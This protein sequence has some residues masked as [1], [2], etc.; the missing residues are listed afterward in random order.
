VVEGEPVKGRVD[1][2]TKFEEKGA[3]ARDASSVAL[4]GLHSVLYLRDGVGRE[5]FS[6]AH[7][8]VPAL[9][10]PEP[11]VRR[12]SGD[13]FD[14]VARPL[15]LTIGSDCTELP[16]RTYRDLISLS[17]YPGVV[18]SMAADVDDLGY[19]GVHRLAWEESGAVV[20]V[21]QA[22]RDT[23]AELVAR[24]DGPASTPVRQPN[25]HA[26][27]W[28]DPAI[29]G[30]VARILDAPIDEAAPLVREAIAHRAIG[31]DYIVSPMLVRARRHR[32][33]GWPN[34]LGA[35][36]PD[37]AFLLAGVK[38]RMYRNVPVF[39]EPDGL[40]SESVGRY[41]DMA[42][43]RLNVRLAR[44]I[45]SALGPDADA[46]EAACGERLLAIRR[47]MNELLLARDEILRVARRE[48]LGPRWARPFDQGPVSGASG[49]DVISMLEYHSI[50]ALNTLN[51]VADNLAWVAIRRS[52][53]ALDPADRSVGLRALLAADTRRAWRADVAVRTVAERLA[54]CPIAHT[55]LG[56]LSVRNAFAHR[57]GVAIGRVSLEASLPAEAY[58]V[59]ALW[60][61]RDS[62]NTIRLLPGTD[63]DVMGAIRRQ[64]TFSSGETTVFTFTRFADTILSCATALTHVT[65]GVGPWRSP[66]GWLLRSDAYKR[67]RFVDRLW[68]NDLHPRLFG[69]HRA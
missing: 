7:D 31:N 69:I 44:A 11:S 45:A 54:G 29:V 4:H 30:S 5:E 58:E 10:T 25:D 52:G 19:P 63:V 53:R 2:V 39:A 43:L 21:R 33:A 42:A 49:N 60:F 16:P 35:C 28:A 67:G 66:R 36:T 50:A 38:S 57:D 56:L 64:A 13:P 24:F 26:S 65:L 8:P 6:T 23:S 47:R 1:T 14:D 62:A 68:R 22:P 18:I 3:R 37:E 51:A 20:S 32:Q 9:A 15:V 59:A 27:T 55:V 48:A 61:G 34:Q 12:T 17:R 46:D 40:V 41:R